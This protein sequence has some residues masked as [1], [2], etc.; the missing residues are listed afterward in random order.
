M[1]ETHL[2]GSVPQTQLLLQLPLHQSAGQ[3]LTQHC[4]HETM[5]RNWF[6]K[7]W[8]CS[9]MLS[10]NNT[11]TSGPTIASWLLT[12]PQYLALQLLKEA[13]KETAMQNCI[14]SCSEPG[15]ISA[16]LALHNK[17]WIINWIQV[18]D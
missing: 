13:N 1:V 8:K 6:V 16:G 17:N 3:M 10:C 2:L 14:D 5:Q 15:C 4:R 11:D 7:G 18:T 12:R 9:K